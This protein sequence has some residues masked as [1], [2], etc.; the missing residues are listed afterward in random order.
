MSNRRW[1]LCASIPLALWLAASARHLS[2]EE[3]GEAG[4]ELVKMVLTLLSDKDKDVRAI[5]F[6]QVRSEAK[7]AAATKEFADRLPKLPGDAQI[8]LLAALSDRGDAAARPAVLEIL[9]TSREEPVRVAAIR[10]I[11]GLAGPTTCRC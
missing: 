9:K 2:A 3:K 6:E 5:G 7:G 10:A 11:G 1:L 4:D 8:G